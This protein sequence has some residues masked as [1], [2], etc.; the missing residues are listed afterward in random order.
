MLLLQRTPIPWLVAELPLL[1]NP[2]V[3]HILKWISS[4]AVTSA[5]YNSV[6]A[7][8]GDL[9]LQPGAGAVN[10]VVNESMS[11]AIRAEDARLSHFLAEALEQPLERLAGTHI[12]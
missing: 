11:A 6:T 8:T 2:R 12:D 3:A 10:G 9:S 7:A 1:L 4:A 5:F